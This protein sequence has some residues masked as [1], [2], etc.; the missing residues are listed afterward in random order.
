M[1]V[2]DVVLTVVLCRKL[3]GGFYSWSAGFGAALP[4]S[5]ISILIERKSRCVSFTD[6]QM[7]FIVPRA[8]SCLQ[9]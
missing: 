2:C 3:L 7:V 6:G 9:A 5:Y 4:A 8:Y 1:R